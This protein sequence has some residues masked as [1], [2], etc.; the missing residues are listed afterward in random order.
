MNTPVLDYV[1]RHD[2]RSL[3]YGVQ[4]LLTPAPVISSWWAGGPVLDQGQEGSCV[5]HA[6]AGELSASPVRVKGMTHEAAVRLYEHAK[7]VDEFEG[8][9]YDGTSVLAAMKVGVELGHYEGY[10][11][12]F[13][14]EDVKQALLQLGP[15]ILGINW[16]ESMYET[17]RTGL[18]QLA[19]RLVGGHC[20]LLTGYSSNYAGHGETFRW[21][22]SWG[23]EYGKNG[24]GYIRAADLQRLLID[25]RGEAAVPV[26]R[27]LVK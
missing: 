25:Q 9:D 27:R 4:Q 24:N 2:P 10:R 22:N 5:G 3:N 19:G 14:L 6:L 26:G 12:A 16:Y 17:T 1:T 18:V 15:V 7:Q 8:V 13:S 11:W 21:R 23:T 20:L